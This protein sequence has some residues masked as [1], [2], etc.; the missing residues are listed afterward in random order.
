RYLL[1]CS[2]QIQSGLPIDVGSIHPRWRVQV[3]FPPIEVP[4]SMN[5]DALAFVKVPPLASARKGRPKGTRRLPTSAETT[6]RVSDRIEKVR[7]CRSCNRIGHNRRTCPKLEISSV[8]DDEGTT[9]QHDDDY[10]F[11]ISDDALC[12]M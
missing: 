10:Q 9:V 8:D 12:T 6:Q 3:T 1:P 5:A 2:H 7:R 4:D 11:E